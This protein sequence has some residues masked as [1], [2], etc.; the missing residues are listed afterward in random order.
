[1][2]VDGVLWQWCALWSIDNGVLLMI[3][4]DYVMIIDDCG[5]YYGNG[6]GCPNPF[7][8]LYLQQIQI[9]QVQCSRVNGVAV[10]GRYLPKK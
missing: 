7:L 9:E 5:W 4:D 1:M 6:A 2:I 8:S 3:V 10:V